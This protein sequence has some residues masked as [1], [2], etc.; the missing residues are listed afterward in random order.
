MKLNKYK[1]GYVVALDMYVHDILKM[2]LF[3]VYVCNYKNLLLHFIFVRV[4][5]GYT[6]FQLKGI[7]YS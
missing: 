7:G 5:Q 3:S 6:P 2:N 4:Q 1:Q